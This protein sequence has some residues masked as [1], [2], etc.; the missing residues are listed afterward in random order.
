MTTW[1]IFIRPDDFPDHIV[2]RRFI[3]E[4]GVVTPSP[5][6]GLYDSVAEAYEDIP[7]GLFNMGRHPS[8]VP[9]LYETWL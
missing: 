7:D 6:A 8:D 5:V 4:P 9:C 2:L 3:V 1:S